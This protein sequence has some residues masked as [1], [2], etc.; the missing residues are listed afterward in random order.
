R[1]IG[2]LVEALR[3]MG[4]EI[5]YLGQEGYPPLLI[6]GRNAK[7]GESEVTLPGNISSQFISA[8]LLIGYQQPDGL[9]IRLQGE[10]LSRPYIEMTLELLSRFGIRHTW[11]GDTIHLP[12]QHLRGGD[13]AVES[14]WS[15][16]SYWFCFASLTKGCQLRLHGLRPDSLQGDHVVADKMADLGVRTNWQ[17]DLLI[18]SG[19]GPVLQNV[20]WDFAD[21]PDLAQGMIVAAAAL[22]VKATFT[23]LQSL[24]IK[25]TDRI[26]AL[27][28][29]LKKF[30]IALREENEHWWLEGNFV[31]AP[32]V[33]ATYEDHRMAMAF[34]PLALRVPGLGI[35]ESEVVKKSYPSFWEDLHRTGFEVR[36]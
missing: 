36:T 4:A 24:R 32:A 11:E 6:F 23:G 31:P 12:K 14:D 8:L 22:G 2:P 5:A 26:L 27:Q 21:C 10:V 28:T 30:G 35:A 19:G 17:N 34:A 29:E 7:F 3:S 16:A 20:H 15:A 13:F 33:I 18:L 9:R 25:E 1:P